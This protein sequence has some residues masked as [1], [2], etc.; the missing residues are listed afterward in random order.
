MTAMDCA[1]VRDLASELA[2][3]AATGEQRAAAHAHL[4]DCAA[5]RAAVS[6]LAQVVDALLVL[7]G[8]L[9]PPPGFESAV[10]A[11]LTRPARHGTGLRR[12]AIAAAAAV[13]VAVAVG[14]VVTARHRV[15]RSPATTALLAAPMRTGD[16]HAVGRA[17][18]SRDG[19]GWV[20]VDVRFD[21]GGREETETYRVELV[22]SSGLV[23][24]AGTLDLHEGRGSAAVRSPTGVSGLR[25]VRLV[26][27]SGQWQ[28]EAVF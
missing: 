8:G 25:G 19:S 6:D 23:V 26:T 11:R 5:C 16:G 9:E 24:P 14:G 18:A 28:C 22:L 4:A 20:L 10:L 17:L 15:S 3:G 21:A 12:A 7:P 2:T 27:P 1:G 13:A